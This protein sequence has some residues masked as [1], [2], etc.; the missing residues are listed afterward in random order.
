MINYKIIEYYHYIYDNTHIFEGHTHNS[1][2]INIV[3]KGS[4]EITVNKNVLKLS[5]GDMA[6]WSPMMFHC[7]RVVSKGYTEFLSIHFNSSNNIP[8]KDFISFY[9]LE[10]SNIMLINILI[11]EMKQNNNK[12]TEAANN[13]FTALLLRSKK[14]TR[15]PEFSENT[16]A[17]IYRDSVELMTE[18]LDRNLCIPEIARYCGV[19]E[20]TLKTAFKQYTGKSIKKYY[21]EFKMQKAKELLIAGKKAKEVAVILGYSSLSYFSQSFKKENGCTLREFFSSLQPYC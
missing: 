17:L 20:T 14:D 21:K 9:K 11:D 15:N 10:H 7:N 12:I 19:C 6:F 5:A 8:L 3:L 18:N 13:L 1:Y 16:S 4:L 2:E